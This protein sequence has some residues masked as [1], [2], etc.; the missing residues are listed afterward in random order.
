MQP[1]TSQECRK[2]E[3]T[4]TES[5]MRSYPSQKFGCTRPSLLI[6]SRSRLWSDIDS[7]ENV[8]AAELSFM[9]ATNIEGS[10]VHKMR[11]HLA[12]GPP[13]ELESCE[14]VFTTP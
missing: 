7:T 4:H 14:L 12:L 9:K 2:T 11:D 10:R 6:S 13:A 8:D 5:R 1:A 3:N